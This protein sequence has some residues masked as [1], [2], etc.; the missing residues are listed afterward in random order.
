MTISGDFIWTL[1]Y[2]VYC[3]CLCVSVS[4]FSGSDFDFLHYHSALYWPNV[5]LQAEP[6]GAV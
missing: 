4:L 1:V 6:V 5:E 2:I 3:S